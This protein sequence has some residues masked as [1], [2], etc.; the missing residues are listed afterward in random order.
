MFLEANDLGSSIPFSPFSN[1]N[2]KAGRRPVGAPVLPGVISSGH[3]PQLMF[4]D[5]LQCPQGIR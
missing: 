1:L 3:Q 4:R 2:G 5:G